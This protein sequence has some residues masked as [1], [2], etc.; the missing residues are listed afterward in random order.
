MHVEA[1]AFLA[2]HATPKA[3]SVLDVGGRDINGSPRSLFPGADYCALDVVDGP[4]VDV[5]AEIV[6]WR[7]R[8]KFDVVICAE[9]LEHAEAWEAVV[10]S[11]WR[12]VAPG[13]RLLVTCATEGREPH[14]A[15]DGGPLRKGEFYGAVMPD[16]LTAC[17]VRQG[18][19]DPLVE[20]H[21]SRGDL[22]LVARKD[23]ARG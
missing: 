6:G 13:G 14:S 1:M 23:R 20:F 2:E 5:V 15:V 7:D 16:D 18:A 8:R 19:K 10:K 21:P 4:G 17:V 3:K 11:C 12:R 9:V 22:Y